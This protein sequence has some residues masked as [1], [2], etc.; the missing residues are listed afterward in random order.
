[1]KSIL[2]TAKDKR[3]NTAVGDDNIVSLCY[4]LEKK[5]GIGVT[6]AGLAVKSAYIANITTQ[7]NS[8]DMYYAVNQ[9]GY[10]M[11]EF[12]LELSKEEFYSR[13]DKIAEMKKIGIGERRSFIE[14]VNAANPHVDFNEDDREITVLLDFKLFR[15]TDL[16]KIRNT[17][18]KTGIL[19]MEIVFVIE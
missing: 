6:S 10:F 13:E 8:K 18:N 17:W 11:K 3:H 16:S 9:C 19:T 14:L 12:E 1:M 7:S 2:E 15:D 5:C 4:L